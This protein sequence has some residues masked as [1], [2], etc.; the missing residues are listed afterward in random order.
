MSIWSS[1]AVWFSLSLLQAWS[2]STR[3]YAVS[4][5]LRPA[6]N[7]TVRFFNNLIT[8][9]GSV[10]NHFRYS[11]MDR[12][13]VC[14]PTTE[15]AGDFPGCFLTFKTSRPAEPASYPRTSYPGNREPD[16]KLRRWA[17]RC[18]SLGSLPR[19]WKALLLLKAISLA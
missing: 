14:Y 9:D 3:S 5:T 2:S 17:A 10:E 6:N 8:F 18:C 7:F 12:K 19:Q 15:C 4:R 1:S 13:H 16:S 11:A